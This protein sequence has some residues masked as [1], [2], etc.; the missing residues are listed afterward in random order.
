MPSSD[1]P[2]SWHWT[3]QTSRE[4]WFALTW[5]TVGGII[6]DLGIIGVIVVDSTA[7][8]VMSV[9]AAWAGVILLFLMIYVRIQ[10]NKPTNTAYQELPVTQAASTQLEV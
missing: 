5:A 1:Q 3:P 8:Q 7:G 6:A 2:S 9:F 4:F 10:K